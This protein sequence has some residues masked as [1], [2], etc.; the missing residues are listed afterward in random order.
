MLELLRNRERRVVFGEI[1][2]ELAVRRFSL[3][4]RAHRYTALY[5]QMLTAP[6]AIKLKK[7]P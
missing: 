3:K 1:C 6:T 4:Q 7:L 2:L 5:T